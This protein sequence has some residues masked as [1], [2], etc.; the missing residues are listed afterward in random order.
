L[1]TGVKLKLL[2]LLVVALAAGLVLRAISGLS[3]G[4]KLTLFGFVIAA[5][6]TGLVLQAMPARIA[7]A[8]V[9]LVDL[10]TAAVSLVATLILVRLRVNWL[11]LRSVLAPIFGLPRQFRSP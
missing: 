3:T 9:S 5:V 8:L 11:L 6:A 1:S 2:G 7:R 4:E 10:L